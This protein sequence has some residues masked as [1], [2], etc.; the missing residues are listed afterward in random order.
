MFLKDTYTAGLLTI[1]FVFASS[2]VP[3]VEAQVMQSTNYRIESDSINVGGGYSSSSNYQL[4]DT[5]GEIATGESESETYSLKA[6]YQQMQ[7]I[8][9]ALT[10]AANV[11]LSPSLGGVTG[12]TSNGSTFA[13]AT[14]DNLAG[15]ELTITAS[16]SP[17][18]QSGSNSIPDYTPVGSDPDYSF[19]NSANESQFG[20]SPEGTDIPA[21]FK[22]NGAS[23]NTGSGNTTSAC[24]DGLSTSPQTIARRTS[25]NHPDGTATTIRFRVE[26]GSTVNQAAGQ[27]VA[28]TTLTL[29]PL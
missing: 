14:T 15:Y 19:T 16:G 9:L 23:C 3:F 12:G 28:T 10:N 21:R 2:L 25:A 5:T 24:W 4:Q 22:D 7:E 1:A 27:Y 17:A 6:G 20:F 26:V 13:T 18:M 29:L 8:Y 11:T